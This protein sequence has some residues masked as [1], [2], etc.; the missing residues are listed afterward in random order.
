MVVG[1]LEERLLRVDDLDVDDSVHGDR[2]VILGDDLLL[3]NVQDLRAEV[4]LDHLVDQGAYEVQSL[5]EHAY[6]FPQAHVYRLLV[7][8]H[9]LHAACYGYDYREENYYCD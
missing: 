9:D 6:E 1:D 2:G 3:G 7:G 8:L 5:V 4:Q